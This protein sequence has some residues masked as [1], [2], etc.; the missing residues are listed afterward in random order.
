MTGFQRGINLIFS[1][2]KEGDNMVFS[3]LRYENDLYKK[4]KLI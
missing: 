3:S 2:F 4:R 1:L